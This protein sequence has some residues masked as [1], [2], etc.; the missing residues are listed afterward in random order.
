MKPPE[1]MACYHEAGHAVAYWH[2]GV[3]IE[4][5]TK[6]CPAEG[7]RPHVWTIERPEPTGAAALESEMKCIAAGEIAD[8]GLSPGRRVPRDDELI[9]SFGVYKGKLTREPGLAE[10]DD[11]A[12]FVEMG[13]ARD[14]D[15]RRGGADA[16]TGPEGWLQIWRA[17]EQLIR[18]ELWPAVRAVAEKLQ[19][20]DRDLCGADVARLA[21]AALGG[22]TR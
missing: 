16:L 4:Y 1:D 15:I 11:R 14:D 18:D 20:S 13:Q 7:Q 22:Q 21:E 5:V 2:H 6:G 8:A 12:A 9:R 10:N 3:A 17:A 19:A